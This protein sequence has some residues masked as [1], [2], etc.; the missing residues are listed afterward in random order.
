MHPYKRLPDRNFW[1]RAV[2]NVPWQDMFKHERAKFIIGRDEVVSSAGSCFAQRIAQQFHKLGY[3]FPNFEPPHPLMSPEDA[4]SF[5]YTTA[6]ARLGNVYTVRELRQIVEQVFA[7]T[8]CKFIIRPNRDDRWVDLLRPG[9]Q[10]IGFGSYEEAFADRLHHMLRVRDMFMASNV[11][12]FTLGLTE[13]WID[14]SGT[15]F[16][17]HPEVA[18]GHETD[19]QVSRLNLDYEACLRDLNFVI[20][21]LRSV[22]PTLKFV[23]TVSPVALAA[24]HQDRHVLLSTS[25]SKS[26]LRAVAGKVCDEHDFADYFMS[27]EIFNAAQSFGQYLSEDLRDISPRGLGTVMDTFSRVFLGQGNSD[28]SASA[29]LLPEIHCAPLPAAPASKPP[30]D[31]AAVECEEAMNAL[32]A[33]AR[34][35][36][37]QAVATAPQIAPPSA[38][39]FRDGPPPAPTIMAT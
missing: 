13:C 37:G 21:Q 28:A 23:F 2:A 12:V 9:V 29:A 3:N 38:D 26:V 15:V 35:G 14:D 17:I 6:S 1:A 22:N 25:Y 33:D 10:K 30:P 31:L 18:L 20:T 32:F 39:S 4:Q 16:G 8:E 5:G 34:P 19:V 24:T 27:Y 36:S 7:L 11:F